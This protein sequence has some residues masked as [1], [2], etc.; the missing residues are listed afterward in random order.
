[1][2]LAELLRLGLGTLTEGDA[3]T[4]GEQDAKDQ[5]DW[6]SKAK[7]DDHEF[8]AGYQVKRTSPPTSWPICPLWPSCPVLGSLATLKVAAPLSVLDSWL[9]TG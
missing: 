7:G 4:K 3:P 1:M 9:A 8:L 2:S 5:G 6:T